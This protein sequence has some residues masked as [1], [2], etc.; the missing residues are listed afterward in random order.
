MYIFYCTAPPQITKEIII[1]RNHSDGRQLKKKKKKKFYPSVKNDDKRRRVVA[2]RP[3]VAVP[4]YDGRRR[5]VLEKVGAGAR[6][7]E[8]HKKRHND[9]DGVTPIF[10]RTF[11]SC[12]TRRRRPSIVER[13]RAVVQQ[14]M[15][16]DIPVRACTHPKDTPTGQRDG[17]LRPTVGAAFPNRSSSSFHGLSLWPYNWR[18]N[19]FKR[20]SR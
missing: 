15:R 9:G 19:S 11:D 10:I 3:F 16:I 5:P 17:R 7:I 12:E 1:G 6:G 4:H 14:I 2:S 13:E 20:L 8:T 18:L